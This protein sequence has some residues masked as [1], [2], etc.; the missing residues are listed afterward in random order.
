MIENIEK[1]AKLKFPND[2]QAVAEFIEGFTAFTKEAGFLD[3]MLNQPTG[4]SSKGAAREADTIQHTI[5]KGI[6]STLGSGIGNLMVT[7]G[8]A[9]A[10]NMVGSVKNMALHSKFLQALERAYQSNRIIAAEP[11]EKVLQYAETI[12]R[13]APNIATDS[14]I[15]SSVLA[16]AIHGEGIYPD[17]IKMLTDIEA[18]YLDNSGFNPKTYSK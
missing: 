8:I 7:A 5:L 17:T 12:F 6:G 2:D 4:Q 11:K 9:T 3:G 13:F 10:G 1:Y 15:L 18:K 14:N 16:N